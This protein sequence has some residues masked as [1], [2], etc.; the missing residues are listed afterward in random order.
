MAI[1]GWEVKARRSVSIRRG[2]SLRALPAQSGGLIP[3]RRTLIYSRWALPRR[4]G[5]GSAVIRSD[6]LCEDRKRHELYHHAGVVPSGG[7]GA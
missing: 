7:Y 3:D 5:Y 2:G 6:Q 1:F 4:G